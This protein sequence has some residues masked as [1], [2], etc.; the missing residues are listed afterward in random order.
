MEHGARLSANAVRP[1][2][3][4]P[5]RVTTATEAAARDRAAIAAGVPSYALMTAAGEGTARILLETYAHRLAHGV[6]LYAGTGNNGG[7]A[8]VVAAALARVG[9]PV[10]MHAVAP[11]TT[12]DAQRA[13]ADAAPWLTHGAP[14]GSEQVVV[15]G[16]LGTGHRG[17]LRE[18]VR[19]ALE[20]VELAQ[21]MGATIVALDL[22]S[23]LNATTGEVAEGTV[24]AACTITFGTIKR[25]LLL[26]RDVVGRV[27]VVDIGLDGWAD[28][29]GDVDDAAWCY[30]TGAA[31][32][33][34]LPPIAWNAH[35]GTRGRI[36]IVGG[37]EGMAGAASWAAH[38]ALR[39]GAGLVRLAVEDRALPV[40][41][42]LAPQATAETWEALVG[43]VVPEDG[44]DALIP[45]SFDAVAIGPGLGR[46]AHALRVLDHV[47]WQYRQTPLVLDADALNL[48]VHGAR[49]HGM[50]PAG[51]LAQWASDSPGI[52]CTPHPGEFARLLEAPYPVDWETRAEVLQAFAARAGVTVLLKG[53]PTLIATPDGAPLTVVPHGTPMLATGGSGDVLTGMVVALCG[54]G[55]PPH[56][57]A[58][59]AATVHGRAAELATAQ[60]GGVRGTTLD[61]LLVAVPAAW[62]ALEHPASSTT[63]VLAE[64]PPVW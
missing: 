55:V 47:A 45:E 46:T 19:M 9:V 40:V 48:L 27:K 20:R 54:Q 30:W 10:R 4:H 17:P 43:G 1:V 60:A 57:A 51:L 6:A 39:A 25:G 37:A 34:A 63:G 13:A 53:A 28:R 36:A 31:F 42:T 61:D 50:A 44:G 8:Y 16:L 56:R 12:P 15:D 33:D 38:G 21:Q 62:R 24:A 11:P 2:T 58:M 52:V 64:L 41:Q 59:I 32:A 26:R 14:T 23:G 35:K 29:P 3:R 22:P 49:D 18:P 5:M 7:D